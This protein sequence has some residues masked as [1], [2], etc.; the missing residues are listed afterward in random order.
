MPSPRTNAEAMPAP[1]SRSAPSSATSSA[2][3]I[4]AVRIFAVVMPGTADLMR[5]A[6]APA[7]GAAALNGQL[8]FM[9]GR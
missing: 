4:S 5:P 2:P 8:V 7:C 9:V 3:L 6:I 1:L